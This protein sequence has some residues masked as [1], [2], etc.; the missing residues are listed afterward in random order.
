MIRRHI[1]ALCTLVVG[2]SNC[3]SPT[4]RPQWMLY[5]A[6]DASIPQVGQ[7]LLVEFLDV[8][9]GVDS[10]DLR[11]LIDGSQPSLWPV[12]IGIIPGATP[13]PR[14]RVRL[15]RLD[16]TGADGL[17]Q[18]TALIDETATLPPDPSGV[19]TVALTLPVACFGVPADLTAHRSCSAATGALAP[20]P[21]L[22]P[23]PD[24]TSLPSPTPPVAC[25]GTAPA[26]M[27]CAPGGLFILGSTDYDNNVDGIVPPLPER[28]VKVDPF[29]IDVDEVEVQD[30]QGFVA[31]GALPQP[32]TMDPQGFGECTFE[33]AAAAPVNCIPWQTASTACELLGK[34]LPREAEWEYVAGNLGQKTTFPWGS[35]PDACKYAVVAE[36]L[37][38]MNI[39]FE[40]NSCATCFGLRAYGAGAMFLDVTTLGMVNLG[41]NVREWVADVY[42]DYSGPCWSGAPPLVNPVCAAPSL[43]ATHTERGG[44]WEDS[45]VSAHGYYRQGSPNDGPSSAVG[46]RCAK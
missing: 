31:R 27:V 41:G 29:F 22:A 2:G 40:C 46:F 17:P 21:T 25:T 3:S 13:S 38:G 36:G 5:V 45:V 30:I 1:A 39:P 12:S 42:E 14:L 23:N 15:Y 20:E 16:E 44:S 19:V 28:L 37:S 11:S 9:T 18:G 43:G 35:D 6:T 7:Q 26:G 10:P 32:L 33:S 4:P 24:L 8:D 34:R